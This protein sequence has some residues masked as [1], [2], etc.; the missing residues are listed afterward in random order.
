MQWRAVY[1]IGCMLQVP[2]MASGLGPLS[3]APVP[4]RAKGVFGQS[5]GIYT[6]PGVA[7]NPHSLP[8]SAS[9]EYPSNEAWD[10]LHGGGVQVKLPAC[11]LAPRSGVWLCPALIN[12]M[13]LLNETSAILGKRLKRHREGRRIAI[14]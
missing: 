12:V 9:G 6:V 8:R 13:T 7:G 1:K 11:D 10:E 14:A 2:I 4:A 5:A 3:M